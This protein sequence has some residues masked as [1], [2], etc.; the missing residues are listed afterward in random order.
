MIRTKQYVM[1]HRLLR[2]LPLEWVSD[3]C[4]TPTQQFSATSWRKQVNVYEIMM[5][6]ALHWTNTLN[7]ILISYLTETTVHRLSPKQIRYLGSE[8]SS[9]CSYYE[10]IGETTNTNFKVFGLTR[11]EIAP[12]IYSTEDEHAVSDLYIQW[13]NRDINKTKKMH[14]FTWT[15]KT[16]FLNPF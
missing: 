6:S 11:S 9:L 12:T 14:I 1:V 4:L 5:R 2:I 10:L 16:I 13:L 3:C 7:W 15:Q 8:S